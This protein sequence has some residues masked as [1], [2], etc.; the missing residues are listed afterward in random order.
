M[1]RANILIPRALE[2][3]RKGV[4][5]YVKPKPKMELFRKFIS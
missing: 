1:I 4:T 3:G 2:L 5:M